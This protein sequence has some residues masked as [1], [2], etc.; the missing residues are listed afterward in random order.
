MAIGYMV[1][2]MGVDMFVGDT[3]GKIKTSGIMRFN[4]F[5]YLQHRTYMG[6]I[7]VMAIP[8]LFY[9]V[10]LFNKWEKVPSILMIIFISFFCFTSGARVFFIIIPLVISICAYI[11]WGQAIK[12]WIQIFLLAIIIVS[13]TSIAMKDKRIRTMY[14]DINSGSSIENIDSRYE[15]WKSVLDIIS[16]E[17]IVGY[18]LG[19]GESAMIESYKNNELFTAAKLKIN[20]HNQY[21]QTAVFGGLIGLGLILIFVFLLIHRTL[22]H[23]GEYHVFVIVFAV[24]YFILNLFECFM[25][26][27]IGVFPIVLFLF[28]I[29]QLSNKKNT[30]N[31]SNGRSSN[32]IML[33]LPILLFLILGAVYLTPTKSH[34]PSTY[35][36][37]KFIVVKNKDLPLAVDIPDY[38]DGFKVTVDQIAKVNNTQHPLNFKYIND[39]LDSANIEM[40]IWCIIASNKAVNQV[41]VWLND[42]SGYSRSS[43]DLKNLGTWQKLTISNI[44]SVRNLRMGTKIVYNNSYNEY[45]DDIY[46]AYPCFKENNIDKTDK[47]KPS[48]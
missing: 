41:S 18:G 11:S 43:Y 15:L 39:E 21:L 26:R 46:F 23:K 27:N 12:W 37:S 42:G 8:L 6:S 40:S 2:R 5:Y 36:A 7:L 19:D 30:Y 3:I 13:I 32:I 17:P 24:Q 35:I 38:T 10:R 45:I 16:E 28:F 14:S 44:C 31:I 33:L 20:A 34:Y 47:I 1:V 22:S 4:L 29:N 9:N 25:V 48:Y